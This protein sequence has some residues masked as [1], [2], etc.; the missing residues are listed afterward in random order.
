MKI[1]NGYVLRQTMGENV[2]LDVTGSFGGAI[3]LNDTSARI[4]ALAAEGKTE[5]EIAERLAEEYEVTRETARRDVAAFCRTMREHG[6]F[7]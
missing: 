6:I 7:Q 3:R 1:R 5:D 4:F 2:L